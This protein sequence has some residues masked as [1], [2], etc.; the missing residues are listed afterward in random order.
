VTERSPVQENGPAVPISVDADTGV[1]TTDG[2]P[3]IYIPRHF[4]VNHHLAI[5]KELGRERYAE[6]LYRAGYKS[7]WEWCAKDSITHKL[8]GL[9]VVRHYLRRIS[10][11]GWGQFAFEKIDEK[12]GASAISLRH[13]VYVHGQPSADDHS[14][15]Y[16]FA[17]WFAGGLEWAGQD[18]GQRWRLQS[19]EVQCAGD[20]KHTHCRFEITPRA[21]A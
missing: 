8:R 21:P 18:T 19:G 20:G 5:E 2:M 16:A 7:T 11:R 17:G 15:C 13:S 12:T 10:Q 14:L 6:I 3:M 4:H 1:W 9:G